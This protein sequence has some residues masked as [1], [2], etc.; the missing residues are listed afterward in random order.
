MKMVFV[1]C[2]VSTL[3]LLLSICLLPKS[4]SKNITALKQPYLQKFWEASV[5]FPDQ[6]AWIDFDLAWYNNKSLSYQTKSAIK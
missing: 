1:A 4:Q 6:K 2:E 5:A 3:L